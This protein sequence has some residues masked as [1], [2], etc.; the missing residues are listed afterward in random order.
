MSAEEAEKACIR[1]RIGG[2]VVLQHWTMWGMA[3]V[4]REL[5]M[6]LVLAALTLVKLGWENGENIFGHRCDK[7]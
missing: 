3:D 6:S 2:L 1:R 7:R 4:A 5:L